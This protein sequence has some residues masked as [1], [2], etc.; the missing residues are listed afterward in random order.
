M[1]GSDL[2]TWSQTSQTSQSARSS[3]LSLQTHTSHSSGSS[4]NNLSPHHPIYNEVR[5]V[6]PSIK[7]G[8]DSSLRKRF[9]IPMTIVGE[10]KTVKRK[11]SMWSL[12]SLNNKWSSN[13][14]ESTTSTT[15]FKFELVN[16][17]ASN[18]SNFLSNSTST[19][20]DFNNTNPS[21]KNERR[22]TRVASLLKNNLKEGMKFGAK[23]VSRRVVSGLKTVKKSFCHPEDPNRAKRRRLNEVEKEKEEVMEIKLE[24]LES[25]SSSFS[26]ISTGQC[27]A[28]FCRIRG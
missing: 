7:S 23:K 28:H 20:Y 3:K 2:F 25:S 6:N 15:N 12:N 26:S 18:N 27:Q 17:G 16:S 14:E 1:E 24:L 5:L 19:Q 21:K 22:K 10:G 11:T 13:K 9:E 4:V 8:D